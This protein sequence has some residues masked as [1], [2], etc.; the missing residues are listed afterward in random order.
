MDKIRS[1]GLSLPEVLVATGVFVTL[2][3]VMLLIYQVSLRARSKEDVH[4]STY[5]AAMLALQH[6]QTQLRGA[7]LLEPS[8]L[9]APGVP[10]AKFLY[11]QLE[12]GSLKV[13]PSG[14][15]TWG[16]TA[17]FEMQGPNLVLRN[18]TQNTVRVLAQ[19]GPT[20]GVAFRRADYRMV[21]VVVTAKRDDPDPTRRSTYTASLLITLPNQP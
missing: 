2:A 9:T 14:E 5:R 12:D 6:I 10:T 8:D 1:R 15:A 4:A 20:G 3:F 19:L 13:G 11:P 21:E 16:D 17:F 18:E 7:Q